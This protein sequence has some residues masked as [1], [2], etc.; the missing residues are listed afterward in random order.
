MFNHIE[1]TSLTNQLCQLET[2]EAA[3]RKVRANKGGPGSDGVTIQQFEMELPKHLRKL[4]NELAEERYYPLPVQKFLMR[5]SN[6][7]N[8]E[9][10]VLALRDRIVQRV[11]CDLLTPIYESKF[12]DCSFGYRLG[13][14]VPHKITYTHD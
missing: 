13:R 3:W 6:G 8:R 7:S 5:K 12:L 10:S 14:G 9:I 2:L 11:V 1:T 4:A